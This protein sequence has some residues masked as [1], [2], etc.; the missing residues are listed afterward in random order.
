MNFLK[1]LIV[2]AVAFWLT[3]LLLGDH[4]QVVGQFELVN[5]SEFIN[6][7]AV[8]LVVALI[9][10]LINAIIKPVATVV[11]FPLIILTLGLFSLVINAL[12]ILLVDW[13]TE[14]TDW[15]LQVNGFWWAVLAAILISVIAS[16]GRALLGA[17]RK[18]SKR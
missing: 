7:G 9:F 13:I 8:F 4:F 6:R 11:S 3:T 5:G 1:K 18:S 2:T 15:G 14:S 17:D 12:I 16:V 10:A